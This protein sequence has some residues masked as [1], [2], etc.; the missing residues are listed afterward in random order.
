MQNEIQ[1][2]Y[3][4]PGFIVRDELVDYLGFSITQLADLLK[5]NRANLSNFLN[6]KT[7]LTPNLALR[8]ARVFSV[9]PEDLMIM[10]MDYDL[11]KA[12]IALHFD[13]NKPT[14]FIKSKARINFA[15][16]D[17]I[18]T[19][20]NYTGFDIP[21][22][23][24]STEEFEANSEELYEHH[25][26]RVDKGQTLLRIDKY[27]VNCM[28]QV[29]R[30]RIQEAAEAGNI[31]VNRAP[32]RSN[33]RVKP[34]DIITIL[35]DYPPTDYEIEPENIPLDIVYEDA[36][37]IV[38]NKPAGMVVHPGVGNFEH[39]LLNAIAWHLH[40]DPFFDANSPNVGLVHRIDKDTSGLL[41]VAKTEAAKSHLGMQFYK[42][43]TKRQYFA[44]VWGNVKAD[45]GT[46][47]G[48]LARDP[49]DRMCYCVW[50]G[51]ENPNAKH[52]VT[53]YK[54]IERLGYVTLVQCQLETGR[55]HKSAFI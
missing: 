51:E 28:S 9:C 42:K 11:D 10:Q 13:P 14:K 8:I 3:R 23:Q 20:M 5:I 35:L 44:L 29:S 43:T 2:R 21:D 54:V 49:R 34:N 22:N 53:H 39:T 46:I 48:A 50:E 27:L 17:K 40:D 16:P 30:N 38:V 37:I 15:A 4:H 6:G 26:F 32:V 31:L 55:T 52:A 18:V 1:P 45:E 25:R 19:Q 7:S 12:Q 36:E 24:E 41:L 33:Y 47:D